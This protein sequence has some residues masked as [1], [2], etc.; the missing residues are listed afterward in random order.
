MPRPLFVALSIGL[1]ALMPRTAS[2]SPS[3]RLVYSRSIDADSCP[4]EDALR[5]AVAAR[6][7]YDPFFP[8]AKHTVVAN[9]TRRGRAFVA[10]VELVDEQGVSHGAHDLETDNACGELLDAVALA[11]AIAIDPRLLLPVTP[12][13]ATPKEPAP[14]PS[15]PAPP[16]PPAPAASPRGPNEKATLPAQVPRRVILEGTVGVAAS[17]G[18]APS[19]AIGLG[20][21]G[22]LR[23]RYA[24][25]GL[26][27]R[28][29]APA[30]EGV[31]SR[32]SVS[33]WL[34]LLAILPCGH[35]GPVF[36]CGVLQGGSMHA[37]GAGL[38]VNQS[39]SQGWW[40]AGGRIGVL[41]P[42]WDNLRLRLHSDVVANL[43]P[44]TFAVSFAPKSSTSEWAA[45]R[46]ATSLG[47][48]LL[49]HF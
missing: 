15:A 29:D 33:S 22:A 42:F 40:A 4:D 19:I 1:L 8:W 46:I 12:N 2:A 41:V 48:D 14:A 27:G 38:S 20:L 17:A 3:A 39:E 44:T 13:P 30:G 31:Q 35:R 23:W 21:G 47:A 49:V 18:V 34:A 24:S 28:I 45:P 16:A 5:R 26:E 11:I 7:G 37:S 10:S 32:G 25:L 6:I 36:A 9:L 43:E